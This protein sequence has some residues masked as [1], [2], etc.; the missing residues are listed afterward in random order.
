MYRERKSHSTGYVFHPMPIRLDVYRLELL[1]NL[2]RT[3][4]HKYKPHFSF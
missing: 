3:R 2:I 1:H 4:P